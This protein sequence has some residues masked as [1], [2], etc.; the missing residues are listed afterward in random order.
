MDKVIK[1]YGERNTNT[2]YMHKLIQLNLE[3]EQLPGIVPGMIM[4]AQR[5]LPG[6]ELVRDM[7][8]KAAF[9]STLGWKHMAVPPFS[10]LQKYGGDAGN[11]GYLTITKN[12]Y[13][14]LLSLYRRP[15][16]QRP[17][18]EMS[19]E[20]FLKKPW[21]T[22]G[23]DNVRPLLASPVDLWNVK[24]KSYMNLP[25]DKALHTTTEQIFKDPS[26]VMDTIAE[27]FAIKRLS[28]HFVNHERSTKDK[29]KNGSYYRDYYINEK[30]RHNLS[31]EAI[32]FINKRL[33]SR[34]MSFYGYEELSGS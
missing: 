17:E 13:A 29:N 34:L 14:W 3:A 33:D 8:F 16:H 15:Y 20:E 1:V 7:Y 21:R 10:V 27:K 22:T 28:D 23:R 12:P 11:V 5:M 26:V 6:S 4:K 31:S 2:N 24:N 18:A 32:E 9:R 30:W 19:F 25:K